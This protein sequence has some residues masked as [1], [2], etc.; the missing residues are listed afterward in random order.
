MFSAK[1]RAVCDVFLCDAELLLRSDVEKRV[2]VLLHNFTMSPKR[3]I[4]KHNF[5]DR[6]IEKLKA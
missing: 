1:V 4:V 2:S 5:S 6:M 3:R